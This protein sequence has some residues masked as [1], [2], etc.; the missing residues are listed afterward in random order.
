MALRNFTIEQNGGD[1]SSDFDGASVKVERALHLS[2]IAVVSSSSGLSS[3]SVKLQESNDGTNWVDISGASEN[4]T[5]DGAVLV[6]RLSNFSSAYIRAVYATSGGSGNLD[7]Q[8]NLK[9]EV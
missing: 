9:E 7:L 6:E 2:V 8:Y 5:A 1:M 3:A 4:L